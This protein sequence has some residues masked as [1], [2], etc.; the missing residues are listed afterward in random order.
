MHLGSDFFVLVRLAKT[1]VRGILEG[2]HL[3]LGN[4]NYCRLPCLQLRADLRFD[5]RLRLFRDI[6]EL[7]GIRQV[8][9]GLFN[10]LLVL[11][12]LLEAKDV[13]CDFNTRPLSLRARSR[14]LLLRFSRVP[15]LLDRALVD[16]IESVSEAVLVVLL[17]DNAADG[18]CFGDHVCRDFTQNLFALLLEELDT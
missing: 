4:G 9:T 17:V 6:D 15:F 2:E 18:K 1:A 12:E 7:F 16:N 3:Y 13:T 14:W 10:R 5:H 8:S 11:V